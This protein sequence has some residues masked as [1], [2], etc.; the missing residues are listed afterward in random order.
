MEHLIF[1]ESTTILKKFQEI[2]PKE[3]KLL[4]LDQI[5]KISNKMD[6]LISSKKYP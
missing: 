4:S 2:I 1:V 3:F 6:I 5:F